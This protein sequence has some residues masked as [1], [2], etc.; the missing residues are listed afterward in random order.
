MVILLWI[1]WGV[2]VVSIL[3]FGLYKDM[4]S[5]WRKRHGKDNDTPEE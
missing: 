1:L 4:R 3:Y 5:K 2:A